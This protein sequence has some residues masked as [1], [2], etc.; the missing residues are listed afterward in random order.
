MAYK[1]L[2]TD[3]AGR[4]ID[5]IISYLVE[6]WSENLAAEFLNRFADFLDILGQYPEAF[7]ASE[8]RPEYRKAVMQKQ[9]SIYYRH[10]S[11]AVEVLRVLDNRI[12]PEKLEDSLDDN[13]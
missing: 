13:P 9:V 6:T 2:L 1:V 4:D 3:E 11:G 12:G 8:I 10:F 7:P 5:Q